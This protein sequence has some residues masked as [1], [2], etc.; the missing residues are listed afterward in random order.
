[1]VEKQTGS[2]LIAGQRERFSQE[3]NRPVGNNWRM[4]LHALSLSGLPCVQT[5]IYVAKH[6]ISRAGL[7]VDIEQIF[8]TFRANHPDLVDRIRTALTLD[9]IRAT[10]ELLFEVH[11]VLMKE[12]RLDSTIFWG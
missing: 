4:Y 8:A 9:D 5:E 2:Q 10:N 11:D 12:A 1:M 7:T 6:K 3:P